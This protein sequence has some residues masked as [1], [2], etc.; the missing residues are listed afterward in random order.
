MAQ[1]GEGHVCGG[2]AQPMRRL[3]DLNGAVI[4]RP[5]GYSLPPG[6]PEYWAKGF[7]DPLPRPN[8]TF[9]GRGRNA[10]VDN[11]HYAP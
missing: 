8:A 9:R 3:Y 6:H 10:R 11:E 4:M 7:D 1:A 2:C 5:W